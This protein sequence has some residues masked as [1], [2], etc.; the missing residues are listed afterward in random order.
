M[1]L[2]AAIQLFPDG[3]MF[4]HIALILVMIWILNKTLFKPI[5]EVLSA[6]EKAKSHEGGEAGAI[7]ED[8]A[9]KEAAYSSEIRDARNEGYQIIEERHNAAVAQRNEKL[10]KV[11]EEV[12]ATLDSGRADIERQAADARR[13]LQAGVEKMAD[14]ITA[15]ILK[16]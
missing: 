5:N 9:R 6:R 16:G 7:L 3:T 8:V 13:E 15:T 4:V 11:K 12:A 1:H 14:H 2:I 10:G